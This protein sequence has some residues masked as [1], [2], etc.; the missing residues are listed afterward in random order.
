VPYTKHKISD[1]ALQRLSAI[2]A[3]RRHGHG[4]ALNALIRRGLV[5]AP[6][7]A[8][9]VWRFGG[10]FLPTDAGIDALA[11]ARREGW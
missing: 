1:A 11:Q 6:D 3:G 9:D 7:G 8:G 2:V 5:R 4:P 10:Q